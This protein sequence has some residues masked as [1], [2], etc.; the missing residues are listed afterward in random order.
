VKH[1]KALS[2]SVDEYLEEMYR[3]ELGGVEIST[4]R[5]AKALKISMP[6]V[7]G[8]LRKLRGKGLVVHEPWCSIGL[9][10]RGR[11]LGLNIYRKHETIKRFFMVLGLGEKTAAEQACRLEHE[12]SD[13]ALE[14]IE[15]FLERA[16]PQD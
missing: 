12:L 11:K 16:A 9:T 15:R 8:M 2:S 7:S 5:L 1:E 3:C 14:H 10:P 4:K 13:R 6:S